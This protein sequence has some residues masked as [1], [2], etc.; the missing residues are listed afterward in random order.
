PLDNHVRIS[1]CVGTFVWSEP[2]L[3]ERRACLRFETARLPGAPSVASQII[4]ASPVEFAPDDGRDSFAILSALP[5]RACRSF[6]ESRSRPVRG[7]GRQSRTDRS[8]D[9]DHC[10]RTHT[11]ILK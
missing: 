4:T 3:G 11:S 5:T 8:P 6:L 9:R 7:S 10:S 2:A 1:A